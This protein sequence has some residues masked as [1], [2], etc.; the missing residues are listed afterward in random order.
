MDD[1]NGS[2]SGSAYI[3]TP[4]DLDPNNWDQ[5]AKLTASDGAAG[6]TF[7]FCVSVSD[8][9]V[10]IGAH[11]NDEQAPDAGAIYV[12]TPN[13]L[14]PNNWDQQVKLTA[15][16]ANTLDWFGYSVSNTQDY[17]IAGAP[18][19]V[20]QTN[21]A[22]EAY[23]FKRDDSGWF[24]QKKLTAE[25]DGEDRDWFGFSVDIEGNNAI[26]SAPGDGDYADD[27]GSA[28]I[29]E[30]C[31]VGDMNGDCC[32]NYEDAVLFVDSW[33]TETAGQ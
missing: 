4:N 21:N 13:D 23:I 31:P 19:N 12:F 6:D 17:I 29:F 1:D 30:I 11:G 8:D 32:V 9:Y 24:E 16:D 20:P 2:N 33:L 26:V 3:F 18:G 28:Y 25:F 22:G 14:D 27:A 5:Q 7:G 15:S 10:V